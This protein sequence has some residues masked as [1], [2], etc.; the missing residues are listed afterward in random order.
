MGLIAGLVSGI[1]AQTR[2]H[3]S[4]FEAIATGVVMG[5][6]LPCFI[7]MIIKYIRNQP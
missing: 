4:M 7:I 3:A 6:G 5:F 1:A 2:D